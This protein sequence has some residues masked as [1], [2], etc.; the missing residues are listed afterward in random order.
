MNNIRPEIQLLLLCL[1]INPEPLAIEKIKE[2]SSSGIDWPYLI[3]FASRHKVLTVLYKTLN[4]LPTGA[5]QSRVL[6]KLRV[7][8]LNNSTRNIYLTE[9]LIRIVS[10]F[11]ENGIESIPFKGPVLAESLYGDIS[12]RHFSDLD[13]LV[14]EKDVQKAKELLIESG[15]KPEVLLNVNQEKIYIRNEFDYK[16]FGEN[17]NIVIELHW[18]MSG[19]YLNKPLHYPFIIQ[20]CTDFTL[21]TRPINNISNEFLLVFLSVHAC[22]HVWESLEQVLCIAEL[23]K[24][25][26][27]WK[28]VLSIAETLN[29]SR[30]LFVGLLLAKNLLNVPL[31]EWIIQ[32]AKAGKLCK[33]VA[34]DLLNENTKVAA[35][36]QERF[37]I[38]HFKVRERFQDKFHFGLYLLFTP[39]RKEWLTFPLPAGLA[40]LHYVL[41]PLRL[42]IS[43]FSQKRDN[44][45]NR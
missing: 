1:S 10:L 38:F 41:R 28:E 37:S 23:T 30:M 40:F 6:D 16:F 27:D 17:G 29:C 44:K 8:V 5:P 39:S 34:L 18:N 42:A 24:K 12:L 32:D 25:K 2:L 31:P 45:R 13:I 22:K 3:G 21:S 20:H 19:N 36:A 7:K 43:F 9:I 4:N 14:P 15:Y 35:P 11:E 26:P 33:T